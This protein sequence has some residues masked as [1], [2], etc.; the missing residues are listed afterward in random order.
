MTALV[1][2]TPLRLMTFNVWR[3]GDQVNLAMVAEAIRKA[4]AD[5]V[6]IQES[7]GNLLKLGNLLGWSHV[8]LR[9]QLLSKYPLFDPEINKLGIGIKGEGEFTAPYTYAEIVPGQIIAIASVHLTSASDGSESL[10]NG[11]SIEKVI[12]QEKKIRLS[13]IKPIYES[14]LTLERQGIPVFLLGDLN[15]PSHLDNPQI[16]WPVSK[17]LIENGFRDSYREIYPNPISHPGLTWTPGYP[18]PRLKSNEIMNRIDYIWVKGNA[19]TIDSFLV[20]EK[21][22]ELSVTPWP[23]DH[24][25]VVSDFLVETVEFTP[26]LSIDKRIVTV[27]D[28]IRFQFCGQNHNSLKMIINSSHENE[29]YYWNID[30]T[31]RS[32]IVLSSLQLKPGSYSAIITDSENNILFNLFFWVISKD[33]KP[34]IEVVSNKH[35]SNKLIGV[36]WKN[37]PGNKWDWIGIYK[38]G[39]LNPEDYLT[40]LY[41]DA[42][43][44]GSLIFDALLEKGNYEIRLYSNDSF[45]TLAIAPFSIE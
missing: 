19:K 26:L 27:G 18:A 31:D 14:L 6:A 28:T 10:Q 23:S 9:T 4:D 33:A 12:Q 37:A 38:A 32:T 42:S 2:S 29:L 45:I 34:E 30:Q 40:Y 16:E 44:E 43:I 13:Q 25:A 11:L 20:G 39:N 8:H 7:E 36:S 22:C 5:I 24:R 3:G 1:A 17:A 21:G 41:L 15:T 35:A